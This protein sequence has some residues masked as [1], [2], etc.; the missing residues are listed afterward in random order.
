MN[1]K[2][3]FLSLQI[4]NYNIFFDMII[5]VFGVVIVDGSKPFQ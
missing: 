1:Y 5:M 3:L 2:N 4:F